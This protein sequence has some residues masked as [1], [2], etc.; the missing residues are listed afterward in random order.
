M[1]TVR[2]VDPDAVVAEA[3]TMEEHL[4]NILL[5]ARLGALFS[6]V[7]AMVALV[8]AAIGLYGVVSYAVA[9]RSREMSIRLSLGADSRRIVRMMVGSGLKLVAVGSVLGLGVAL[10]VSTVLQ[11]F[12]FEVAVLDP[13]TFL[14]V[15]ALFLCVSLL[16]AYV[17]ARRVTEADPVRALRVE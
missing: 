14:G 3:L 1:E 9:S 2:S 11:S 6:S 12:L 16:A 7:F 15:P 10:L 8:L 4:E 13:V 5:P 17:P